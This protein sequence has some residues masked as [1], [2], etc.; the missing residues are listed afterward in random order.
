MNILFIILDN[1]SYLHYFPLGVAYL[2]TIAKEE[3]HTVSIYQQDVHHY[4]NEHLK[5]YLEDNRF[6]IIG[7]GTISGYYPYRKLLEVSEII[8]NCS[9]RNKLKYIIGGHMPSADPEYFLKKTG[10]DICV[11][12]EGEETF[13][14][15]LMNSCYNLYLIKG[16]Y[17]QE[18]G[19]IHKTEKRELI[20]DLYTISIPD[21]NLF[22]M[23]Y[24]RLQRFPNIERNEFSASVMTGRGCSFHCTFCYRISE[25]I[26]LRSTKSIIE[27]IKLLKEKYN[28]TYIDFA[29]DLTMYSKERSKE[30]CNAILDSKL[31]IKWRCEGRLNYA[32]KDILKLMKKSGCVFINYGI[33][34][35]DNQVL[36][37][38]KKGLTK[39]III[40]GIENTLKV[41]ISP[42]LNFM[43]GNI[44]DTK[45]SLSRSVEFLIKYDDC[46]QI[47]TISPMTPYPGSE[48]FQEAIKRGL[49]KDTE[50]F[51]ENKYKNSDLLTVNFTDLDDKSFHQHLYVANWNLLKNYYDKKF[52][53]SAKAFYN[54]YTGLDKNFRGMRHS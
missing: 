17:Y 46:S 26:R 1:D 4:N 24:Y 18:Y 40:K 30:L 39:D 13:R 19:V 49:L 53:T 3:G 50:D 23:I 29:D 14:K 16:I 36:K 9:K 37:N 47:R 48:V 7:I 45:E 2:A 6:D 54:L 52:G 25:G 8:N 38:I 5:H 12:G 51:Y 32:S 11:V 31:H 41:G 20:K 27:E 35:L 10:A 15:L 21:Y 34:S 28:I 33:E 42:G 22:P 44:G 43:W